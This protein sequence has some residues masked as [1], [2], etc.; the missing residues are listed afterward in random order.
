MSLEPKKA[1]GIALLPLIIFVAIFLW[2]GVQYGSFYEFPAPIAVLIGIVAAFFIFHRNGINENVNGFIRGCG[3]PSI[4]MMCLIALFSGAFSVVT[5]SIGATDTFVEITKNYLSLQYLYAGVFV[6]ASF[7]SF[8]SG[9]SVGAVVSLAP[10]A[11]GFVSLPNVNV[12]LIAGSLLGGAMFGDNLSF[13]SDTTIAATQSQGCEMK[14]KFRMNGK[15]AL[16]AS[17]LTV[18]TLIIIGVSIHPSG[19][20]LSQGDAPIQWVNL[21]PYITVIVLAIAGLNVYVTFLIGTL[22]SGLLGF[23]YGSFDL[24]GYCKT[25]FDGFASMNDIFLV[26]LFTGGLAYLIEREG[27]ISFLTQK[28]GKFINTKG[29]AFFG[30]GFLVALIDAAVANNTVAIVISAPVAKK[31][32]EEYKISP[33]QTASILDISSCVVQ[34]IIPYGAQVLLLI[35]LLGTDVNYS[36]MI[37]Q[38]FYIWLLLLCMIVFFINKRK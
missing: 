25:V 35:K 15:I 7:L 38:S 16:P 12:E 24:L 8:A 4:L 6:I 21:L 34:G 9:T 11:A 30:I 37:A 27:G 17:V 28:I 2:S 19:H 1:N 33:I 5:K 13:I 23:W 36:S 29:R 20:S 31:I 26:F 18:L 22:I 3:N 32:S 10:I 14:D